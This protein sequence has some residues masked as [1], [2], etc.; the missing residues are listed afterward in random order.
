MTQEREGYHN[1]T[2]QI[3]QVVWDAISKEADLTGESAAKIITRI[4]AKHF[5][6]KPDVLPKPKRAGRPPKQ[7]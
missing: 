6:I 2:T 1:L 3:P 5:R 4:V 7:K